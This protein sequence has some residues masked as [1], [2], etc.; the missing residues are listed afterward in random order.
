MLNLSLS[1]VFPAYERVIYDYSS[2]LA[3]ALNREI[4]SGEPESHF[5]FLV[6]QDVNIQSLAR[7]ICQFFFVLRR[8]KA[9][10]QPLARSTR[11]NTDAIR[12]PAL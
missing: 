12:N 5:H 6:S 1:F 3:V 2:Y 11:R 4:T 10:L 8:E 9:H 7:F